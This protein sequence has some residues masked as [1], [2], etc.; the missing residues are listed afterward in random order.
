MATRH[1]IIKQEL[2]DDPLGR[3]YA[4][5]N[6]AAAAADMNAI[7]RDGVADGNLLVQ[8]TLTEV[9]RRNTGSDNQ[10]LT[11]YARMLKLS[12]SNEGDDVF[13]ATPTRN[14]TKTDIAAAQTILRLLDTDVQTLLTNIND[15]RYAQLLDAL[16]AAYVM[17]QSNADEM[18]AFSQN[19]RS[20]GQEL[21]VGNVTE[22]DI[23]SARALP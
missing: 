17:A 7:Y 2:D 1:E 4:G 19:K 18:K 6:D 10:Q 9:H 8:Y 14:A 3:G 23:V 12:A 20:R 13:G 21:E 5:M 22:G 15:V 11:L 16:V